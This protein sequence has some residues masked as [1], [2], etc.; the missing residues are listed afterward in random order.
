VIGMNR[1]KPKRPESQNNWKFGIIGKP[2]TP[3]SRNAPVKPEELEH[4]FFIILM[5]QI[6]LYFSLY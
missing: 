2:E 1:E 3:K 5:E 6:T 4:L